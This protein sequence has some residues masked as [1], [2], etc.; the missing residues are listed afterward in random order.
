M[1]NSGGSSP[2]QLKRAARFG[3]GLMCVTLIL[4]ALLAGG[5]FEINGGTAGYQPPLA[6]AVLAGFVMLLVALAGL[7]LI[8]NALGLSDNTAA[9]GL[10]AGSIRAL[11]ALGLV[12]VFVGVCSAELIGSK[13]WDPDTAKQMLAITATALTTIVGFYFGSNSANEAYSAANQTTNQ[14]TPPTPAT[15]DGLTHQAAGIKGIVDAL[16][17]KLAAVED[18]G[19]DRI[20]EQNP[21]PASVAALRDSLAAVVAQITAAGVDRDRAAK[22]VA[23]ATADASKLETSSVAMQHYSADATKAQD[24]AEAALALYTKAR[25]AMLAGL[26]KG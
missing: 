15:L 12:T 20:A 22:L 13:T 25:D 6:V 14:D 24:A 5:L 16:Q 23:D 26:A 21:D 2:D 8:F 17:Q 3:A 4:I 10:P 18:P 9:L 11:L 19:P 7:V 1:P